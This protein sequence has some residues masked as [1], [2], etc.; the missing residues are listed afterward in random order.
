MALVIR[1]QHRH[2]FG[3]LLDEMYRL[4]RRVFVER[5]GWKIPGD[6]GVHETDQFDD[7]GCLHLVTFDANGRVAASSRLTPSTEPNVTCD[8]LQGQIDQPLPRGDHIVEVSRLCVD[9]AL[10]EDV[11]KAALKDLRLSQFELYQ[12][13]GWTHVLSVAYVRSIQPWVRAG[14]QVDIIGSPTVFPGDKE[15]SFAVLM[16]GTDEGDAVIER[17]VGVVGGVLLDP[18]D[19]PSLLDRFGEQR[20]A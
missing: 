6:D 13:H 8:V 10:P 19:T 12:K 16:G 4:R 5:L 9:H 3:A 18:A 20:A 2:R 7:G 11:R 14:G 1:P 17:H 15:P